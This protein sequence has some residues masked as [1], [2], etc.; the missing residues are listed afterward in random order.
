MNFNPSLARNTDSS[1]FQ[2][3]PL[4]AS[5]SAQVVDITLS[6]IL[7]TD[8]ILLEIPDTQPWFMPMKFPAGQEPAVPGLLRRLRVASRNQYPI[9]IRYPSLSSFREL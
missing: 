2:S 3:I 4:A 1:P 6:I 8:N 9:V 7:L 5:R